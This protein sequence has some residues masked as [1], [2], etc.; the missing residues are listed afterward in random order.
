MI[1]VE[2]RKLTFGMLRKLSKCIY[3]EDELMALAGLGLKMSPFEI[4]RYL[5]NN[6][7]DFYSAT[8][9]LLEDWRETQEDAAAAYRNLCEALERVKMEFYISQALK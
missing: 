6:P 9:S 5:V 3:E 4:H 7:N 2:S 1:S 8:L